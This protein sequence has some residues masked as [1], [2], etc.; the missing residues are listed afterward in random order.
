MK[1][2]LIFSVTLIAIMAA[3]IVISGCTNGPKLDDA[4]AQCLT[5]KATMYGT[6]WC[7]HCKNQK[8]LFG[9]SFRYITY[10]DCDKNKDEC[11]RNNIEGYPTW[12]IKGEKHPG[13]QRLER[14]ADLTGCSLSESQ[15]ND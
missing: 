14:L 2:K 7:P 6:E 3:I 12:I 10:I 15:I 5:E 13:E 11:L 8:R 4:F 1:P 9:N